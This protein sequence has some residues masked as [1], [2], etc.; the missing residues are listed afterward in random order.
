MVNWLCHTQE[1]F[2]IISLGFDGQVRFWVN[3]SFPTVLL[4]GCVWTDI[5]QWKQKA[6]MLIISAYNVHLSTEPPSKIRLHAILLDV[7]EKFKPIFLY[8]AYSWEGEQ[9]APFLLDSKPQLPTLPIVPLVSGKLWDPNS[10]KRRKAPSW[11]LLLCSR[12]VGE[13]GEERALSR[14]AVFISV[15]FFFFWFSVAWSRMKGEEAGMQWRGAGVTE[16]SFLHT[17][18]IRSGTA[19]SHQPQIN[20]TNLF[21]LAI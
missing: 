10:E 20:L 7:P 6:S 15:F 12:K 5:L 8:H 14:L 1:V 19:L 16:A 13:H 17:V 21:Y 3:L 18:A 4:E 2:A 11:T 9:Q